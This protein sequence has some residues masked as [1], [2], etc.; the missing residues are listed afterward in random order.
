[1]ADLIAIGYP[2]E[3]TAVP[4][5]QETERLAKEL[6]VQ[7]DA[8]AAI[9]RD[10]EGTYH[11]VTTHRPVGAG[12][13]WGGLRGLPLGILFFVPVLGTAVGAGLG[14]LMGRI[15]R[16]GI[17][18]R[19]LEQVRALEGGRAAAAGAPARRFGHGMTGPDHQEA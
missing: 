14:A 16:S 13:T 10:Q 17:D 7:P 5:K 4:A 19:F 12:T 18:K 11:L 3:G 6:V 2:D 8:V 9:Q 15:E 1:M